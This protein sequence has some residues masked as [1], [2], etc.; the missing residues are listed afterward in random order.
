MSNKPARAMADQ[1]SGSECVTLGAPVA[2]KHELA[3]IVPALRKIKKR[4][5]LAASELWVDHG[6]EIGRVTRALA[7]GKPAQAAPAGA[8]AKFVRVVSWNIERGKEVE[9]QIAWLQEERPDYLV[10]FPDWMCQVT[11]LSSLAIRTASPRIWGRWRWRA[12][13]AGARAVDLD[14][15]TSVVAGSDC[16]SI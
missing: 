6:E 9:S 8:D 13:P 4:P 12:L 7:Y 2:I 5:A 16:W 10:V 11:A 3:A 1:R 14:F 15:A